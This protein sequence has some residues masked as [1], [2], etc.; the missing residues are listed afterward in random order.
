MAGGREG[1]RKKCQV[2]MMMTMMCRLLLT[3]LPFTGTPLCGESPLEYR[4]VVGLK[5][6]FISTPKREREQER[7][8]VISGTRGASSGKGDDMDRLVWYFSQNFE[9]TL[10]DIRTSMYWSSFVHVKLTA[11]R[12]D[13]CRM[14][15]TSWNAYAKPALKRIIHEREELLSVGR[16]LRSETADVS[17]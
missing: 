4:P 11:H 5:S 1:S 14:M 7:I 2:V 8:L 12:K 9:H 6:Y 3:G 10:M 17:E 16:E 13:F 15:L